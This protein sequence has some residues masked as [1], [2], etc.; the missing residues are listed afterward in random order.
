[1]HSKTLFNRSQTHMPIDVEP[2]ALDINTIRSAAHEALSD[3]HSHV[4][5]TVNAVEPLL[6]MHLRF[7]MWTSLA[8][9]TFI[10]AAFLGRVLEVLIFYAF[11]AAFFLIAYPMALCRQPRAI[12]INAQQLPNAP[13]DTVDIEQ[14]PQME[15]HDSH[16]NIL[17]AACARLKKKMHAHCFVVFALH[18][19]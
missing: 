14:M 10:L 19:W 3:E 9:A 8:L 16:V 5:D 2:G 15:Q 4:T 17:V 7:G 11:S 1:M 13:A 18:R 12:S 6:P